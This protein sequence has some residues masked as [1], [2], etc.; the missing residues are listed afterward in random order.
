VET[1]NPPPNSVQSWLFPVLEDG[2]GALDDTHRQFVAVCE[3]WDPQ[4]HMG[5]VAIIDH[6][7]RRGERI[8]F[9]P[10]EAQRPG[11]VA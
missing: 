7:A 6:N 10:A 8:E 1:S 9:S 3:L 11:G 4:D 5:H 2:I